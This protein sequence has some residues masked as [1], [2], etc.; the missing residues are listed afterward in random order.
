MLVPHTTTVDLS[1]SKG[2]HALGFTADDADGPPFSVVVSGSA[3]FDGG[4]AGFDGSRA[5]DPVDNG[6]DTGMD[7]LPLSVVRVRAR[8]SVLVGLI[9]GRRTA[10]RFIVDEILKWALHLDRA[11]YIVTSQ[12]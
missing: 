5:G 2:K 6:L 10:P 3:D 9:V 11:M 12:Q 7:I 1:T 4:G 8:V